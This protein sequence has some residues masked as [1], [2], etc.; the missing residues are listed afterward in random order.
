[1]MKYG[2]VVAACA[3]ALVLVAGVSA[4]ENV[5]SGPQVGE[6]VPGPFQPLNINGKAAGQKNCLYCANGTNP[7]AMVF[8]RSNSPEVTALIKKLD[9]CTAKHS[10][11][12][13]G[14][15]VV[16]LSDSEKLAAELKDL[17]KKEELKKIVLSIDNPPGPK[18]Y[19]VAKDADV[20]VVLY[21]DHTVK[22][23]HSFKKGELKDKDIEKIVADVSKILPEK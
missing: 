3:A 12:K 5:K 18:P 14:S 16:Y 6:T 19:K 2:M 8:A 20:T 13:M 10:D 1:M 15:F 4:G 23:N 17:A 11:A 22:A 7:V 21:T 9:A